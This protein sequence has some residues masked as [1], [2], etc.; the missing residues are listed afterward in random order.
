MRYLCYNVCIS[1]MESVVMIRKDKKQYKTGV[2]THVRVVEGYRE[3]GKIKQRTIKSF[4]SL[5][6]QIDQEKFMQMVKDFDD[7]YFLSK[8][9]KKDSY[10]RK[11]NETTYN[12]PVNYGYKFLESIYDSLELDKFFKSKYTK[13]SYNLNDIFKFLVIQRILNPDSKRATIQKKDGYYN[14]ITDFALEDIYRSLTKYDE[15]KIEIQKYLNDRIKTIIGRNS[16]YAYYD[17]TNYY[18]EIDVPDENGLRKRGVSKEHRVDPIVQMGLF[19]D[20]NALPISMSLFSGNTSDS[21]TLQP[22]MVEIKK[23]YNLNRLIVVADKGLNSTS[24]INYIINN[25]DGYVVSQILKGKKGSRYQEKLF[26]DSLYT[27]NKDKT[28][29]YQE[30]IEDYEII[31]T[32]GNKE[33][34]KR[35][36][37]IYWKYDDAILEAKKRND[38]LSRALNSLNNNAYAIKHTYEKYIKEIHSVKSTGEMADT[39]TRGLD[40]DKVSE[41][42]KYDGYFC[43]ITSEI[44]Y[45]YKKILEVYGSLWKI[46]E[47]FRITKNELETRPIYLSTESHINGHFIICFVA[48]LVIRMLQYKMNFSMS[49]ERIVRALNTSNCLIEEGGSVYILQNNP[50]KGYIKDKLD[51]DD[52]D[53]TIDDFIKI[54]EAYNINIPFERYKK[55]NFNKYLESIKY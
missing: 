21:K 34:K 28:F 39:I 43:L 23:N 49:I 37:L 24:N 17:V 42:A 16:E 45:D 32:N 10:T 6:D 12:K 38:K 20:N 11:F 2:K 46:E 52:S 4:G 40:E 9:A 48:L 22:I 19:I 35:K 47:S 3:N 18:F 7:N 5:E 50:C 13:A 41:D 53:E 1:V 26:N 44:D 54:I 30:F 31:N 25:D 14:C 8:K 51:L 55:I 29:K 36:V 27:Y 33:T 15:F